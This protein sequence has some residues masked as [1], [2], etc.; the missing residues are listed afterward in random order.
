MAD[1]AAI[2]RG[3]VLHGFQATLADCRSMFR[4][5]PVAA[6]AQGKRTSSSG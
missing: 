5:G 4:A 1:V 2:V 6:V 3:N